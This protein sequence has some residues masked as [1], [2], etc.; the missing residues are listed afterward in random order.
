MHDRKHGFIDGNGFRAGG[1]DAR[2][3]RRLDDRR[4]LDARTLA[5]ASAGAR[6][7]LQRWR[8]AGWLHGI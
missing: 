7:L 1:P 6:K 8:D 5:A 4:F 3:M 2:L